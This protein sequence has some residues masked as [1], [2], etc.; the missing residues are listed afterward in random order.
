MTPASSA[1]VEAAGGRVLRVSRPGGVSL[2]A[3]LFQGRGATERGSRGRCVFLSGY[4]EFIEKHL[5]SIVELT[6]RGFEVATLDWRGQGLSDRQLPDRHKGHIDRMETHLEDLAA[7]LE[8][9]DG[10]D[11]GPPPTVVAHSMGAHL[12]LRYCMTAPDRVARAV[13]IAPML[14]IGRTGMPTGLARL[15]VEGFSLTPMI[16]SYILGGAGYGERRRRFEGNPLTTD[17]PQFEALHRMLDENPDLALGDPTF[18]WVRAA[19]RSID[20]VM[21]PGALEAVHTPL[22]LALAGQEAIVENRAIERAAARLPDARL[23]RFPEARHEILREREPVRR[24]FWAA[25]DQF[26]ADTAAEPAGW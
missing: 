19:F 20:A 3:A 14:G 13:L 2:R 25:V 23:A 1:A 8:A 26:L 7:V 11:S 5:G 21:A 16:D 6:E 22:L 10:F 18:A 17:R 9:I 24:A 12:A 4:T 15:L